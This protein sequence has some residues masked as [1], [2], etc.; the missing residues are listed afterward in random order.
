[1]T[2]A[3]YETY[4]NWIFGDAHQFQLTRET[5][6][7]ILF[8]IFDTVTSQVTWQRLLEKT[9]I[10]S[11]VTCSAYVEHLELSYLCQ[12]LQC[13]DTDKQMGSSKK[14]KKIYFIDPLLYALVGGYLRGI[15]NVYQWWASELA[16]PEFR[17]N[18]FEAVVASHAARI[19]QPLYYWY[20]ANLKREADLLVTCGDD[21]T[22]YDV[23][24]Q[25]EA[26]KPVLGRR[27]T[28]ITPQIFTS[29]R[30]FLGVS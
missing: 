11:H 7:H 14:S 19:A 13:Y 8:R 17:G 1:M 29:R 10:K 2:D 12:V 18:I 30:D 9:P 26:I 5:L 20:S 23:K 24:S 6:I 3:T 21:L 15:R 4:A 27:V 22:L 28:V 16:S 25:S